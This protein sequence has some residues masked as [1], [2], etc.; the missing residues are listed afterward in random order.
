MKTYRI[1]PEYM[2]NWSG[3]QYD[4]DDPDYDIVTEAQVRELAEEWACPLDELME[5]LEEN[6]EQRRF[7]VA[8]NGP[9]GI[10]YADT[11]FDELPTREQVRAVV[12]DYFT[13]GKT[14]EELQKM[15]EQYD[16]YDCWEAYPV[17]TIDH[18]SYEM[19][20]NIDFS[21]MG[22]AREALK[23]NERQ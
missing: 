13:G 16:D 4:S 6:P 18:I 1:K 9:E 7:A 22:L 17:E 23:N 8:L 2:D 12:I 10:I 21:V 14:R 3:G 15:A 19:R 11:L 5:Q 20:V